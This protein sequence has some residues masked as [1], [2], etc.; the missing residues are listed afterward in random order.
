MKNI[1]VIN[2]HNNYNRLRKMI[3]WVSKLSLHC[4][5]RVVGSEVSS[6]TKCKRYK[7]VKYQW[8]QEINCLSTQKQRRP[9]A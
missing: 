8:L 7:N 3:A 6:S 9:F 1:A 2:K 4:M 5:L